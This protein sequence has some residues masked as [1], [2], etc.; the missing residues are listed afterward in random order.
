MLILLHRSR[1]LISL[2]FEDGRE[3]SIPYSQIPSENDTLSL[4]IPKIIHQT[5]K[6]ENLP[7]HWKEA[8]E[9]VKQHHP[10][11]EYMVRF[12][13]QNPLILLRDFILTSRSF[14]RIKVVLSSSK[15]IIHPFSPPTFPIHIRFKEWMP[16]VICYCITMAASISTSTFPHTNP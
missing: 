4:I 1:F 14:G 9:A 15:L 2:L 5:Y 8:Q 7:D 16:C 3:D 10:D 12:T 11:Y 6:D 13:N